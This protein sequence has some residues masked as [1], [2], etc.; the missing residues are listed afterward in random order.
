MEAIPDGLP[1][2]S[3]PRHPSAGRLHLGWYDPGMKHKVDAASDPPIS[4]KTTFDRIAGTVS[5]PKERVDEAERDS[6][7][8]HRSRMQRQTGRPRRIRHDGCQSS[9]NKA[10]RFTHGFGTHAV[11]H[12]VCSR[13]RAIDSRRSSRGLA[14]S[15]RGRDLREHVGIE[16]C[17]R[18]LVT[19]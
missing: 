15:H 1:L 14:R 3:R 13:V 6:P 19:K 7:K 5:G 9:G 2:C 4:D 16:Q 8:R 17:T 12:F 11:V 18:V 10:S